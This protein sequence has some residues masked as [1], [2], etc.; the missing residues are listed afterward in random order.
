MGS[1]L[2]GAP[3]QWGLPSTGFYGNKGT[4]TRHKERDIK[5]K[6]KL[7]YLPTDY[8]PRDFANINPHINPNIEPEYYKMLQ[9]E[10]SLLTVPT[11]RSCY[12]KEQ[13]C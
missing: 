4:K 3:V 11:S 7:S 2:L 10:T 8:Q 1:H 12:S 5:T 13:H 9:L 6:V